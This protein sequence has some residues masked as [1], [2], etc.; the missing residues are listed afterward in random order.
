[1]K[2][3][4]FFNKQCWENWTATCKR[5]KLEHFLT[6][7]TIINS[8]WIKDLNVRPDTLKL[9]E[10]NIGRTLFD[11]NCNNFLD[12]PPRVIET[13]TKIN[14]CYLIKLKSFCTPKETINEMKRQPMDWEKIFVNNATGKGLISKI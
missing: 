10:E 1:M 13:K 14:K 11:I 7:Y 12:P 5:M 8:K 2:T 4:S 3:N 6:P 9:L